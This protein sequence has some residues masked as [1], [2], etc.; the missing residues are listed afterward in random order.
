MKLKKVPFVLSLAI[1]ALLVVGTTAFAQEPDYNGMG[2][3][4]NGNGN[5]MMD[6]MKNGNMSQMMEAMNSFEGQK[7][8]N[9]CSDFMESFGKNKEEK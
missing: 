2:N 5:E 3:M 9:A 1:A 4:L 7:M 8:M 6:M